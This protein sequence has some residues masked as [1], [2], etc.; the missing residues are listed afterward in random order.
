MINNVINDWTPETKSLLKGLTDAGFTLVSGDNGE[1]R[2][3]F[4]GNLDKF[5]ENLIACDEARLYIT[6]PD[7][8]KLWIFLVLGNEPG[9]IASDYTCHPGLDA[10]TEAHYEAWSGRPQPK[11]TIEAKYGTKR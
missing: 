8:K 5:I 7:G 11:T 3:K 2:F 4:D 10:V 6:S 9:V 1:D